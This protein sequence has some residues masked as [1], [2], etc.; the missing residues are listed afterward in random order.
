MRIISYSEAIK[1]ELI[2]QEYYSKFSYIPIV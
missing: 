1:N 2:P